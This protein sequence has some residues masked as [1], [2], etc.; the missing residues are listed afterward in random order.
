MP[1]FFLS[2]GAVLP[3]TVWFGTDIG[4]TVSVCVQQRFCAILTTHSWAK[5]KKGKTKNGKIFCGLLMVLTI[6]IA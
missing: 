6:L 5:K 2:I 3:I 1:V 4:T